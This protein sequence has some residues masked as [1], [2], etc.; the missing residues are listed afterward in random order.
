[1]RKKDVK[2]RQAIKKMPCVVCGTT[3]SDPAHIVP[4]NV[5]GKDEWYSML[6]LCRR[7]HSTQHR[8]G[9]RLFLEDKPKLCA[10]LKEMGWNWEYTLG[11]FIIYRGEDVRDRGES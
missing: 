1:M 5:C 7:C 10:L 6:P 3:P 8:T 11:K 9:W 4:W 2:F